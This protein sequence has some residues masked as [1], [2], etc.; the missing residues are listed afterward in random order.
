MTYVWLLGT[1]K[2]SVIREEF[3]K[4][5]LNLYEAKTFQCKP[6]QKDV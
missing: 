3:L 5:K 1:Y 2:V 4:D 6:F